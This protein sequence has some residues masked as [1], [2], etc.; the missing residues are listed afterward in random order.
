MLTWCATFVVGLLQPTTVSETDRVF[1][2]PGPAIGIQ[3]FLA[4]TRTV[5]GSYGRT[6]LRSMGV[7][8]VLI[9]E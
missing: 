2:D 5:L 6:M 9:H 3:R 4:G 7:E 1:F 8:R